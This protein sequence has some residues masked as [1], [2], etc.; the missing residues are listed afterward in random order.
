MN[1]KTIFAVSCTVLAISSILWYSS[2]R[3]SKSLRER[4]ITENIEVMTTTEKEGV[5]FFVC[6]SSGSTGSWG[7]I[8]FICP[9]GT[10]TAYTLPNFPVGIYYEC[11]TS[12]SSRM[13]LL[14]KLGYCYRKVYT[15]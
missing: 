7:T 2:S 9:S 15:K 3:K 12:K 10:T 1:N 13:C 11:S 5:E 14:P 6:V 8:R 4:L